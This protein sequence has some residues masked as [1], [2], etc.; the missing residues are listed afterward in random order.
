MSSALKQTLFLLVI[1]LAPCVSGALK[2]L[3]ASHDSQNSR[4]HRTSESFIGTPITLGNA[5]A[6]T[7]TLSRRQTTFKQGPTP[8]SPTTASKVALSEPNLKSELVNPSK[9]TCTF[10][11][12][13][14]TCVFSP[15]PEAVSTT[16]RS[17][18]TVSTTPTT[19]MPDSTPTTNMPDSTPTTNMPDSTPTTNI[20]DSTP[21]TN[22]P[23]STPTTNM[24]DST[25][26]TNMP[27]STPTT[28]MPDSTP[29]TNMPDSTPTTNMQ[30]STPTTNMPDSS[31]TT[32][33]P[34]STPTTNMLDSTPT[35]NMPDSTP[36]TN[37]PDSTPTTNMPDS[38][39]FTNMPNS[40]PT[41]NMPDSTPTTN[42]P[43][44]TPAT[45]MPDSTPTTN[46]PDSTSTT[47]MPDSTPTTNM[48]DSTPTTNMPDS[49]PTTNMPDSTPTTNMPDSTPTTNMPDSTPTTNMPDFTPTTNMPDSTPTTNMPD[50]TPTT[51]MPDS[52]STTN[53]PDSTPITKMPDSTPTTNMPDSTPTTNKPDST[54]TTNMPDSTPTT[55]I[56]DS[57]PTTNMPDST[58][59]TNMPDSTPTTNMRN[60]TPTTNMPDS[61]PTT[62]MPDSTPTTNMPDS[63]PITKMPDSTPTTNMPDSTP[64]TNMPDSTPTTNMP[65]STPT[66]NVPDSTPTTN[67][68]DSTPTTNMPDSTPTTNMPDSTLT[69]YMPDS[70]PTTNMPDSTPTTNMPDSTPNTNMP[71]STPTTNMPDSTPTTNM[72]DSTPTTNMPDSTPN[73][74]MSNFTTSTTTMSSKWWCR[75]YYDPRNCVIVT[76]PKAISTTPTTT[77]SHSTTPTTPMSESTTHTTPK[78]VFTS[79]STFAHS[80]TDPSTSNPPSASTTTVNEISSSSQKPA[81]TRWCENETINFRNCSNIN[82]LKAR[83]LGESLTVSNQSDENI[84][85]IV[86]QMAALY[87]LS[88]QNNSK[89]SAPEIASIIGD[90]EIIGKTLASS[91]ADVSNETLEMFAEVSSRLT[92]ADSEAWKDEPGL[93]KTATFLHSMEQIVKSSLR[94]FNGTSS[95]IEKYP[96]LVICRFRGRGNITFPWTNVNSS[97][98]AESEVQIYLPLGDREDDKNQLYSVIIYNQLAQK[99]NLN[100]QV[101]NKFEQGHLL[102]KSITSPIISVSILH[103]PTQRPIELTFSHKKN[104]SRPSCGF[105]KT[106]N[107]LGLWS[108]SGCVVKSENMTHVVCF[109][110]HLT[111]FG[112]LL[113]LRGYNEEIFALSLISMIGCSLSML[114]LALTLIVFSL[115]WRQVKDDRTVL[116]V[117]LSVCL[118]I[119]YTLFLTGMD[120][121]DHEVGCTIVAVCLHY[122]FLSAI[123]LMLAEGLNIVRLIIIVFTSSSKSFV[124]YLLLISY[125]IPMVIVA[126]SLAITKAQGYGGRSS[127]WLSVETG[128]IWSFGAPV[129][130]VILVNGVILVV[131][132]RKIQNSQI[133]RNLSTQQRIKSILRAFGVLTPLL[134]LTWL[135]GI[136]SINSQTI[137]FQYIFALLN[138]TQGI[139]IFVFHCLLQKKTR[140]A[141]KLWWKRQFPGELGAPKKTQE[142]SVVD[143]QLVNYISKGSFVFSE[144]QESPLTTKMSDHNPQ[145]SA[146]L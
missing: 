102:G 101:Q 79:T 118:F 128:L 70:T 31:P 83:Q 23:D 105:L 38:T 113:S 90:F 138:S 120:K 41:T 39:P 132:I 47:N 40:T 85:A 87:D 119:G 126:I 137:A 63:T 55:N 117:N 69:T 73:T 7:V 136:F 91:N 56:P 134:G 32:N 139:F 92:S 80:T 93:V 17:P 22:M 94:S 125:G 16:P 4:R 97:L 129:L 45:N 140:D 116:H 42:M 112:L 43:D 123:F 37:M 127:C 82:L 146:Q 122:F 135:F 35:T 28:N 24:P 84:T 121:T 65:D 46:M 33:I 95:V 144:T 86:R 115:V 12:G 11:N 6:A 131:A 114:G 75:I 49:T 34:D 103:T 107:Q 81:S 27:D 104:F 96:S 110:Q 108:T 36:T 44:S 145:L 29:T 58:P 72:P 62:N 48:P 61:T 66:T 71:D 111:N 98:V 60:S 50:S 2:S 64:T 54:P 26:T 68:R 14:Y 109:C 99:I 10:Y 142:T 20:P 13:V 77:I 51:N 88:L 25:P 15:T 5:W 3:S 76:T 52:T 74:I 130:L 106:E 143:V 30:N 141:L 67:M 100:P 78:A 89:I 124:R 8:V 9:W 59:T 18:K 133:I 57:T 53:M 1:T 19:N 21:T